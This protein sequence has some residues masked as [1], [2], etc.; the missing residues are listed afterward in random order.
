MNENTLSDTLALLKKLEVEMVIWTMFR[1]SGILKASPMGGSTHW[2]S[3]NEY[4]CM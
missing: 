4:V 1:G 2:S 3:K